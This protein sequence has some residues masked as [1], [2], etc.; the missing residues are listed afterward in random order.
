MN[1]KKFS[2]KASMRKRMSIAVWFITAILLLLVI[3]LSYIMTVKRDDYA[4]RAEDQW[5]SEV[6]I[7][8]RRG[9]ILDR[10]GVE[11]AVSANVYRIDFDLNSVRQYLTKNNKTTENIAPLIA[12]ASDIPIEEVLEKLETKLP[13]GANAGSATLI[14]RVEK[15]TADRVKE[16]DIAGVIVSPDTKRYYP[17]GD[18]LAHALGCTNI[19]G[20]GLTGIELQYNEYLSG[21][22]GVRIT[23]LD[24]NSD[25]LPYTI[26]KFTAPISG[27]DV[28]ST[29]DKNIQS[30]AE[31]V[32][33]K[34]L[35]DNKAKRVSIL[36]TDCNTGEILAM[37]NK[38]DYDPNNPFEG[39]ENFW[40]DT[41]AE[42]LQK[43]WR[44][45]LVNDT[46]EPGSI[47]KVI[48]MSAALEE[49]LVTEDNTYNCGGSLKVGPHT[50]KCW[51][52]SGHGEQILPQILQNSCNVGFMKLGETIGAEKLNEYIKKFGFGQLSGIDLPGEARGIIKATD[53]INEADL[54][55]ISFGQTNTVNAVQYMTAYNAVINGGNLIQPHIV[56]E[57]TH[58]NSEGK[59][60]VDEVFEPKI[61]ENIISDETSAILRDYLERTALQGG[62]NKAYVE[63]Y[64]LGAKTGTAQKVNPLT[65]GYES[66]K[67]IS[68]MAGFAPV[69]SPKVSI[70]ISIDEPSN[71]AYYAGQVVAPLGKILFE[72]L[73]NY[74]DSYFEKDKNP[75]V[76]EVIIPEIR[77]LELSEVKEI[78]KEN[79]LKYEIIGD[80]S[81]ITNV[82]PYPGYCIAEGKTVT[83]FT[84][85]SEVVNK[86]IVMPSLL[87]HTLESAKAL[88]DNLEIEYEIQGEGIVNKQSIPKGEL[89]S[90]Q[91]SVK[92][93]L[94]E[95]Y[96]D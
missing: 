55:T 34:G 23:E 40:G 49:R 3:R 42:Q 56:K 39:Y 92:L 64:H 88:L 45:S 91:T 32:A 67:Y 90:K 46:F 70:F 73:F 37:V 94:S 18:F 77:D 87:G 22:P 12:E 76:K 75:I 25:N 10:N 61:T 38:N 83:I 19:D 51:K 4:T 85:D 9:R 57:I 50:I 78:L 1:K 31:K 86:S 53:K 47:F 71:G 80:G 15:E 13:S 7:D 65:G 84:G 2:D 54:A 17:E 72:D 8:A 79:N 26:S 5:T 62:S 59:T 33:E 44:N 63:G 35:V 6:R 14:R 48:T 60:I 69:D 95:E 52:T 81:I 74:M 28:T 93:I 30:F 29:I 68:S 96:G 82:Q 27:K 89:I 11:L 58:I 20:Q 24:R 16:L 41:E 66:G 43:M 36:V 21:V